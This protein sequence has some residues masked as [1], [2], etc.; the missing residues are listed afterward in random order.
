MYISIDRD[1]EARKRGIGLHNYG[2]LRSALQDLWPVKWRPK[3]ADSVSSS[4]KAGEY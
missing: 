1:L 3:T 4:P 2:G